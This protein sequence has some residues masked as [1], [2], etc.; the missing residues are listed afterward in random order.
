[1]NEDTRVAVCCYA[2]DA[3]Q[4]IG[5]LGLYLHHECPVVFLSPEDSPVKVDHPGVESRYGGKRAYTGKDSLDRER[6]HLEILLE[7]PETHFMI[8]D[9][10]SVCLDAKFPD[11]LYAEPDV[12]WSNQVNDDIPQH[13]A[14]F[15]PGWPHVAFQPPYFLSRKTIQAMLAVADQI[16][17]SPMMPFIDYY[18][19]QLTCAAGLPWKRFLNCFSCPIA[20]DPKKNL[21]IRDIATYNIG[22]RIAEDHIL[23]KGSHIVHSVKDPRAAQR[24]LGWR[25]QYLAK[26]GVSVAPS[27]FITWPESPPPSPPRNKGVKA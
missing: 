9:A 8:H 15:P 10:D 14:T 16:T 21:S 23:N 6:R 7:F 4:A 26:H 20:G 11:Y 22:I 1:M 17:P 19:V 25:R 3:H 27:P 24:L 13:Q 18:M 5:N 2:G 12:V